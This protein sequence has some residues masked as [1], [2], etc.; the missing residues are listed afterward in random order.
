M[1]FNDFLLFFLIR[2]ILSYILIP[3]QLFILT[4][5]LCTACS[6]GGTRSALPLPAH[7]PTL[8]RESCRTDSAKFRHG[9]ERIKTGVRGKCGK[10]S[11][12]LRKTEIRFASE[13][14][15]AVRKQFEFHNTQENRFCKIT[16]L[17]WIISF[18]N[19]NI[20]WKFQIGQTGEF[21]FRIEN[22]DNVQ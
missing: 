12:Y 6:T 17:L 16:R 14:T 4:C 21:Y 11:P 2:R 22:P 7:P 10:V 20:L 15:D 5:L 18:R 13:V 9:R 1:F 3:V 8:A 19:I